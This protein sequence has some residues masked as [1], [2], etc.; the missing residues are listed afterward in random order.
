MTD[1]T[2][3]MRFAVGISLNINA[4][5]VHDFMDSLSDIY[6]LYED[7]S[8]LLHMHNQTMNEPSAF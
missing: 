5:M 8:L 2:C 7:N 4:D 1:P 3:S 6:R